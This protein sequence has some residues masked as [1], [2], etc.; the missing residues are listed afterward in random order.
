[1]NEELPE[2][3]DK[4]NLKRQEYY[5]QSSVLRLTECVSQALRDIEKHQSLAKSNAVKFFSEELLCIIEQLEGVTY[6][7]TD[8]GIMLLFIAGQLF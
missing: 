5:E 3:I 8:E 6:E 2:D 7:V 1:M 4:N